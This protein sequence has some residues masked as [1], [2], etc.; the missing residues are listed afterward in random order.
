MPQREMSRARAELLG[1][2]RVAIRRLSTE[3]DRLDHRAANHFGVSRTDLHLI[4]ALRLSGPLTPSQLAA[5]S[6]LTSGGL[7]I[8]L[9]RLERKGYIRRSQHPDDRRR[10]LVEA[11]EA[12]AP[13]EAHV[14][15][16][17]GKA[18]AALLGTYDDDEL[19]V[20]GDYLERAAVTISQAGPDPTDTSDGARPS[21]APAEAP[22]RPGP[23]APRDVGSSIRRRTPSP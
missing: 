3:I 2:A 21:D 5:S 14:F 6:G 4:E 15:G 16:P 20:I 22:G 18:M 8:A 9:E 11:T 7:S 23:S 13:L 19:R 12:I 10:V 17:V 1:G